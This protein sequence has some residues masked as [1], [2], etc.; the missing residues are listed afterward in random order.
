MNN[1]NHTTLFNALPEY[2]KE[3]VRKLRRECRFILRDLNLE[4]WEKIEQIK[5]INYRIN[6]ILISNSFPEGKD[7]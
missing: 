7:W 6:D 4:H 3:Q 1:L 2:K 5:E